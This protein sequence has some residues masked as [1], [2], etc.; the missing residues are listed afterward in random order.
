MFELSFYVTI[1]IYELNSY[2]T[3]FPHFLDEKMLEINLE[4]KIR[5]IY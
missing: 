1:L 4:L 3:L 5:G 2:Q